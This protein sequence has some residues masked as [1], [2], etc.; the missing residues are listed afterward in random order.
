MPGCGRG[1]FELHWKEIRFRQWKERKC[2]C[3]SKNGEA[4]FRNEDDVLRLCRCGAAVDILQCRLCEGKLVARPTSVG[5]ERLGCNFANQ[6]RVESELQIIQSA[7]IYSGVA[8]TPLRTTTSAAA[9]TPPQ[10]QPQLDVGNGN[11]SLHEP[12]R[13]RRRLFCLQ[14][15]FIG[16][17]M[18]RQN[19]AEINQQIQFDSGSSSVQG[20]PFAYYYIYSPTKQTTCWNSVTPTAIDLFAGAGGMSLGLR[21]AGFDVNFA[22]DADKSAV[23]SHRRNHPNCKVFHEDVSDFL[24][25]IKAKRKGYPEHADHIHASPPCQ[26]FSAAKE[27]HGTAYLNKG[28]NSLS[29]MV[30][31]FVKQ[32]KPKTI[33]FENVKGM[34]DGKHIQFLR[35]ITCELL[36]LG[37]QVTADI[38]NAKNFGVPQHRERVILLASK[39]GLR[40]PVLPKP[41]SM[42]VMSVGQALETLEAVDPVHRGDI[43]VRSS[44]GTMVYD[45]VEWRVRPS[46]GKRLARHTVSETVRRR[47]MILHYKH[48][49]DITMRERARLQAF[50]DEYRFSGDP[51]AQG[52]Q[53]GN[54]VPVPMA[55]AVGKSI[56]SLYKLTKIS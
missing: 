21:K 44:D 30:I 50:P 9:V 41:L 4:A 29:L 33:S 1:S 56:M 10:P 47:N 36:K 39:K 7:G 25:N 37:Y 16:A 18:A 34:V 12:R 48:G 52:D 19:E 43:P 28:R 24:E 40:P 49:R 54:A 13:A 2:S 23:D 46:T 3:I 27:I 8:S 5:C 20:L 51:D 22:V 15:S 42:Q 6:Y 31:D 14:D 11:L 38:L 17:E 55:E 53:I 45:H 35:W 32:L 26:D